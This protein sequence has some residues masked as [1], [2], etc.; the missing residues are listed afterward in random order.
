M[1]DGP[2][3]LLALQL[4]RAR[5]H[6]PVLAFDKVASWLATAEKFGAVGVSP[7]ADNVA[8]VVAETTAGH[9][10]DKVVEFTGRGPSF[11]LAVSITRPGG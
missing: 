6:A 8:D 9:G 4:A 3:G 10:V 5:T 2:T 1:P 7:D 11:A